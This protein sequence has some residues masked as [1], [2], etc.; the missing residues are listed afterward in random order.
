[1]VILAACGETT[2]S[3]TSTATNAEAGSAPCDVEGG[4]CEASSCCVVEGTLVNLEAKCRAATT[5]TF[6]CRP[7]RCAV[8]LALG[9]Y[10]RTMPDGTVETYGTPSTWPAAT[11]GAEFRECPDSVRGVVLSGI[12]Q[13]CSR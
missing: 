11:L 6:S 7:N 13:T 5:T 4:T 2:A 3:S 12:E 9:C 10:Q 1:M 8:N